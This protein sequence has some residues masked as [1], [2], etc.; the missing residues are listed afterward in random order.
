M[1]STYLHLKL[2][3]YFS[4]L[5]TGKESAGSGE[6][7]TS[8]DSY[9]NSLKHFKLHRSASDSDTALKAALKFRERITDALTNEKPSKANSWMS[10][11]SVPVTI[12]MI[13]KMAAQQ[14]QKILNRS[15]SASSPALIESDTSVSELVMRTT[16]I[17]GNNNLNINN[18]KKKS[19]A[20]KCVKFKDD[21]DI[22]HSENELDRDNSD[23]RQMDMV[24]KMRQNNKQ[25]A[26]RSPRPNSTR[27]LK[28]SNVMAN[29]SP[30]NSFKNSDSFP[31]ELHGGTKSALQII[32]ETIAVKKLLATPGALEKWN[33][34]AMSDTSSNCST[35]PLRR[36]TDRERGEL[37][38]S[39]HMVAL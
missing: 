19:K 23:Y 6:S 10:H 34:D 35:L 7:S 21:D 30:S 4:V 13:D 8:E 1:N 39:D 20:N 15:H 29:T 16:D 9:Y 32:A 17:E 22:I 28:Q 14:D 18:V 36:T 24:V 37:M 33:S 3:E 12:E 31:R 38:I 5:H 27:Q 25:M 26:Q 11:S 2:I